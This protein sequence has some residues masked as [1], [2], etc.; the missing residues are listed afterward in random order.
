MHAERV[1]VVKVLVGDANRLNPTFVNVG[2][3]FAFVVAELELQILPAHPD[4]IV[5][6]IRRA[7]G[8]QVVDDGL[9]DPGFGLFLEKVEH[10]ASLLLLFIVVDGRGVK[11]LHKKDDFRLRLS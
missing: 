11:K 8:H 3:E 7:Y 2:E 10:A 6:G 5:Y 9:V 4:C 1:R